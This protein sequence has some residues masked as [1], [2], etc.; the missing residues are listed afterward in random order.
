MK[1]QFLS[2]LIALLL[3]VAVVPCFGTVA[4]AD[5]SAGSESNPLP[6]AATNLGGLICRFCNT[7]LAAGDEDGVWYSFTADESGIIL[8]DCSSYD[9]EFIARMWVNGVTYSSFEDGVTTRPISTYPISVGDEVLI[10]IVARDTSCAGYVYA[11]VSF[12]S[13]GEDIAETV[14]LKSEGAVVYV[15][16]GATVHYQD[17][18]TSALYIQKG[19]R[20]VGK[21]D[22][23]IVNSVSK[24]YTDTDGDGA[25]ELVLGG[26]YASFGV[27]TVKPTWAITN[28]TSED[29]AFVLE[30]VNK[31]HECTYNASGKCTSCG[32]SR[33][34]CTHVYDSD[35]DADCN[36]CGVRREAPHRYNSYGMCEVCQVKI[37]GASVTAGVDLTMKYSVNLISKALQ[38]R[39]SDV[40]MR[41]TMNGNSV[42]VPLDPEKTDADGHY[43]FAFTGIAPQCMADNIKAEVL[44]GGEVIASKDEYSVKANAEALLS[45]YPAN[46][47]LGQLIVD[48]LTYGAAAQNYKDYNVEDLAN[49]GITGAPS[50]ARPT[51]SHK[52]VTESA[53]DTA[54]FQSATVRFDNVNRIGVKLSTTENVTLKVNGKAVALTGTTYYTDAI[55]ATGFDNLYTFE[56]YEGGVLVQTLTYSVSSYVYSM[57]DKTE[58]G[59]PTEMAELAMALYRYGVSAV[60]YKSGK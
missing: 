10:N 18:S 47:A 44:L 59:A 37:T 13:G 9:V 26:S 46:T 22:G 4:L 40:S 12:V 48:M 58:D 35:C 33:P 28:K 24:N 23:I 19:L 45:I 34:A 14:K 57:M 16:A 21:T 50:T 3:V 5:D 20:V 36:L 49:A 43:V 7:S 1:K 38:E 15:A 29:R 42:T 32:A 60:A 51:E 27:P 30:V 52:T 25:V 55:Y 6:I 2:L 39:L 54:F 17:D 53:S 31:A 11:N 8:F 41:F 56:L